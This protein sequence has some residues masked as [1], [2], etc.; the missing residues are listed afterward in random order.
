ML[1]KKVTCSCIL[2]VIIIVNGNKYLGGFCIIPKI[3]LQTDRLLVSRYCG[4]NFLRTNPFTK[5]LSKRL[6]SKCKE[7]DNSSEP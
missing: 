1:K 5:P 6:K 2:V 4:P 3:I 7:T